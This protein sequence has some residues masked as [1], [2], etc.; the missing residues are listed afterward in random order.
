[1]ILEQHLPSEK[2][3]GFSNQ[4]SPHL[5][6][7]THIL[8]DLCSVWSLS[9]YLMVESLEIKI[10]IS[11]PFQKTFRRT[12]YISMQFYIMEI[13]PRG[14]TVSWATHTPVIHNPSLYT[15]FLAH[16]YLTCLHAAPGTTH[17]I[18]SLAPVGTW[19]LFCLVETINVNSKSTPIYIVNI[20][21]VL[22]VLHPWTQ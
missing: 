15:S 10:W 9:Q 14:S 22:Q 6:A 17:L 11:S 7:H 2:Q 8:F 16:G 21:K 12:N 20:R 18:I 13:S 4:C 1:M 5:E 19:G 3:S